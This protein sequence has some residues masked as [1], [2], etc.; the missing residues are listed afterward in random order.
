MLEKYRPV[1]ASL[2]INDASYLRSRFALR[3]DP[4][5][6]LHDALAERGL[7]QATVVLALLHAG[8]HDAVRLFVEVKVCPAQPSPQR[9]LPLPRR[10]RGPDDRVLVAIVSRNPLTI[11]SAR[12]RWE[13]MRRCR[14][15][16]SYA[17]RVPRWLALRDVR[18]WSRAGWLEVA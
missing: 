6:A 2:A 18:E 11:P 10:E 4:S 8:R 15:V 1:V 12:A 14:T 13:L 7:D 9:N 17:A 16:G 3:C 5:L